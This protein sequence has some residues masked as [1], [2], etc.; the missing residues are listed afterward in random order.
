MAEEFEMEILN[1]SIYISDYWD[2]HICTGHIQ[3]MQAGE[4][5]MCH[6]NIEI[7]DYNYRFS[8]F[9][10]KLFWGLKCLRSTGKSRK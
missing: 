8:Y 4:P 10:Y 2:L 1:H 3:F 5:C 6:I 9:L 7:F